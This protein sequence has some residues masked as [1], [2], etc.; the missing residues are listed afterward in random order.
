MTDADIRVLEA[1]VLLLQRLDGPEDCPVRETAERAE[2]AILM[3]LDA[4]V[5]AA[6]RPECVPLLWP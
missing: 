4:S 6:D 2:N 3:L 1:A 5:G